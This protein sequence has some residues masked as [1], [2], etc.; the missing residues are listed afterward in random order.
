VLG[1]ILFV[2]FI[3]DLPEGLGS[4]V[5][6]FADD[7]KLFRQIDNDEDK[8]KLQADL[9]ELVK[10]SERWQL[11]F[12]ETK[13][14]VLHLGR[15][16]AQ[17]Q[18]SM[19][20]V[21][22]DVTEEEKDLGVVVDKELKFDKHIA[23]AIKKANR[24]LGII[25]NTFTYLD[26]STIPR[27]YMALVRPLIEYGNVI[28]HPSFQKDKLE[29][30]K[31]QRRATKLVP[32][33][34]NLAYED[35][36]RSLKLPSMHHRRRRGD[37]I[38]VYKII[39][40]HDRVDTSEFFK[41]PL[42]TSTRGHS[43]KLSVNRCRLDVRKNVFSNRVVKDWNSLPQETIDSSSVNSFKNSLDKFWCKEQF[44]LP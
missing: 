27:L 42:Y 1:P 12:N 41:A 23:A 44:Q 26:I 9:T 37:M 18:Y 19:N 6:I 8:R 40:G 32:D 31:V 25:R 28:W 24:V 14:K 15:T 34:R 35:R 22:L 21:I 2:I 17:Q 30:E 20:G 3:N 7:T 4:I 29:I 16:N 5:K 39:K 43:E 38:Q 13:C 33:M 10:W 36:L 11:Q